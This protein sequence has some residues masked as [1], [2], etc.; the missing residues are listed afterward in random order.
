MGTVVKEEPGLSKPQMISGHYPHLLSSHS[1]ASQPSPQLLSSS[2]GIKHEHQ[3]QQQQQEKE[4]GNQPGKEELL[5][6]MEKVDKEIS[7]V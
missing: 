7:K 6:A 1:M 2:I 3:P 5:Q 4:S